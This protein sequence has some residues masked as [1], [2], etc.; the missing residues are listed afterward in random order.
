MLFDLRGRGRRRTIQAIYLWLAVL[1]AGG[2]VF[3]GI[4]G[5]TNGG[6]LDAFK[7]GG[8]GGSAGSGLFDQRL[9][10]AQRQ[11]ALTPGNAPAWAQL[12]QL[13]FQLAGLG[14]NYSQAQGSFTS[15][16][17]AQL[18]QAKQAWDHYLSLN[19]AQPNADIAAEMVQ[20][21]GGAGGL[22]DYAAASRAAEI[23]AS[24]RP[25]EAIFAQLA[26][27]S[28][29]AG[30]TRKG[31]LAAA[32]AETLAPTSSRAALKAQLQSVRSQAAPHSRGT[33]GAA[34]ATASGGGGSSG[35]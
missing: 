30:Q 31:D 33:T 10:A 18:A 6:L 35:K 1:M 17:R 3:F 19:P 8:G 7:S 27:F 5:A 25:N 24:A 4:G 34:G 28:Y 32:K 22:G 11:V 13:R 23:V 2:L 12:A 9:K 16:G 21:F 29:L 14:D 20:A 15:K 26:A